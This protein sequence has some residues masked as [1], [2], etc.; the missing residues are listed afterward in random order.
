LTLALAILFLAPSFLL[1]GKA[2]IRYVLPAL[3]LL[4]ILGIGGG[5]ALASAVGSRL[6]LGAGGSVLL[7]NLVVLLLTVATL[8]EDLVSAA[9]QLRRPPARPTWVQTLLAQPIGPDDLL[10]TEGPERLRFY[11]GRADYHLY[12]RREFRDS[13]D[14]EDRYSYQA[15]DGIRSIYTNSLLISEPD[16]FDRLVEAPNHGRTLWV[17]GSEET[18]HRLARRIEGDLWP[19]LLGSARRKL[20]TDDGWIMLRITLPLRFRHA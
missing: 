7:A 12:S 13:Q 14:D 10:L 18:L 11:F 6:R 1:Q 2:E 15:V 9:S 4:A 3:P 8:R 5:S 17:V 19:S 16:D 20:S